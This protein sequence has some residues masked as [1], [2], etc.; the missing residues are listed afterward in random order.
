MAFSL[1]KII[2]IFDCFRVCVNSERILSKRRQFVIFK[3]AYH[4]IK[5]RIVFKVHK[6]SWRM[7][8]IYVYNFSTLNYNEA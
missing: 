1:P 8:L 2:S 4:S 3:T 7:S 5:Q 6:K